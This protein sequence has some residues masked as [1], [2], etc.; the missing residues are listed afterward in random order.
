MLNKIKAFFYIFIQSLTSPRYY[1]E[2]FANNLS[3]SIKYYVVLVG[4]SSILI[5]VHTTIFVVP[6]LKERLNRGVEQISSFYPADLEIS[7]VG[8]EWNINKE[9]PF[10]VQMPQAWLDSDENRD[11]GIPVNLVVFDKG[12]T[13]EDLERHSSLVIV[14][15]VNVIYREANGIRSFKLEGIPE[16]TFN[17][18]SFDELIGGMATFLSF[19]PYIMFL[20]FFIS[21]MFYFILARVVYLFVVALIVW[22]LGRISRLNLSYESCFKLGLHAMT[23]P[24]VVFVVLSLFRVDL[25]NFLSSWFFFLNMGVASFVL[26]FLSKDR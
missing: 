19:I 1:R 11:K 8:G 10:V 17:R 5:A 25:P 26:Y 15:D 20:W 14:N 24:V 22:L 12:G 16:G 18:G 3:L 9:M 4:L 7:M 2:V 13:I 21:L 23:L 6:D